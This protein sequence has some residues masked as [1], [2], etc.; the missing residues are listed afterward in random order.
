VVSVCEPKP[1]QNAAG[2]VEPESVDELLSH[3]AHRGR[4]EDDH[5]LLVQPNDALIGP[6]IEQLGKV[7]FVETWRLSAP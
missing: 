4:A 1:K 6:K 5:A 3:E 7:Q 2:S